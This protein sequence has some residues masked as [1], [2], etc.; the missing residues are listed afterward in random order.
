MPDFSHRTQG[1]AINLASVGD[2]TS[3][4]QS[5]FT[6]NL[7]PQG[8]AIYGSVLSGVAFS[9][10][11]FTSNGDPTLPGPGTIYLNVVSG[12]STMTDL[13]F[14]SNA[15]I[16]YGTGPSTGAGYQAA[17]WTV[18]GTNSTYV[19]L[20]GNGVSL[21]NLNAFTGNFQLSAAT[22]TNNLAPLGVLVSDSATG[23]TLTL[24]N[25]IVS[26]PLH[27]CTFALD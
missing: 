2:V 13:I 10:V 18:S 7:A 24:S 16:F 15:D 5:S 3:I 20:G 27:R 19:D 26:T 4:S 14:S 8:P 21:F 17:R 1:G 25:S 23:G 22:F 9:F 12:A 11:N 6:G